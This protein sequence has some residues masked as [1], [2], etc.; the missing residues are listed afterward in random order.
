MVR[1]SRTPNLLFCCK[2]GSKRGHAHFNRAAPGRNREGTQARKVRMSPTGRRLVIHRSAVVGGAVERQ[3][4]DGLARA[5][6]HETAAERIESGSPPLLLKLTPLAARPERRPPPPQ[7][8][9]KP[10]AP[11]NA[12]TKASPHPPPPPP[13]ARRPT[14]PYTLGN[15]DRNDRSPKNSGATVATGWPAGI[16]GAGCASNHSPDRVAP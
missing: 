3:G 8:K 5:F 9:T 12:A 4:Q 1:R 2:P 16:S 7:A 13:G 11:L 10:P 6:G 15:R 14:A